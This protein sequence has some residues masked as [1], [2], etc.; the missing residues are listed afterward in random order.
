MDE[1]EHQRETKLNSNLVMVYYQYNDEADDT[2]DVKNLSAIF[3]QFLEPKTDTDI[4]LMIGKSNDL[5]TF[6]GFNLVYRVKIDF[7]W[8]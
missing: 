1:Y 3:E 6:Y 8:V 4:T 5:M 2:L 7:E